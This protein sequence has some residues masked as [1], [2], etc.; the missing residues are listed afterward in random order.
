[1]E[2]FT[3]LQYRQWLIDIDG[4][5]LIQAIFNSLFSVV[6]LVDYLMER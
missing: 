6:P 4:I 1:M 5:H 2:M 3:S